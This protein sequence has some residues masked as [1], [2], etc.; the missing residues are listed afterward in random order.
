MS[1][2]LNPNSSSETNTQATIS[3]QETAHS[4]SPLETI[5]IVC[6]QGSQLCIRD[7]QGRVYLQTEITGDGICSCSIGGALGTHIAMIEDSEGRVLDSASFMV[8][9]VTAINDQGGYFK[10]IFQMLF[11]TMEMDWH[12]G[13]TKSLRIDGKRYKYYVSWL[14]DHVHTLKGMK[15]FDSDIKTGIEL[16]SDSQRDDGMIWD[17]VKEMHHSDL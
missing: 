9:C 5:H 17:K 8:S 2:Q 7:G 11:D 4:F 15:Y 16:Y 14:R 12:K 13:Y 3:I 1:T 6:T 10:N